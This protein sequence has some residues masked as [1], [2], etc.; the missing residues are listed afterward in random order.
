MQRVPKQLLTGYKGT[1][2]GLKRYKWVTK[3]LHKGYKG[4]AKRLQSS[5][6]VVTKRLQRGCK[7]LN[8]TKGPHGGYEG[9]GGA[10]CV[11]PRRLLLPVRVG[12]VVHQAHHLLGLQLAVGRCT[13]LA[14][15]VAQEPVLQRAPAPAELCNRVQR[16][17]KGLAMGPL[18]PIPTTDPPVPS[19]PLRSPMGLAM[20]GVL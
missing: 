19:G 8:G 10:A 16:A 3:G 1:A 9:S 6:K 4:A 13:A 12:R 17:C 7:E 5:Y 2:Q 18:F 20:D 15:V 11:C 14:L